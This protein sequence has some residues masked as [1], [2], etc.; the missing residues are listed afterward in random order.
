[1]SQASDTADAKPAPRKGRLFVRLILTL[2][3]LFVALVAALPTILSSDFIRQRGLEGANGAVAGTI[4]L[5]DMS[6]SWTDG[7]SLS[8]LRAWPRGAGDGE[9]LFSLPSASFD[10]A[11]LPVLSG[12]FDVT[13]DVSGFDAQLVLREDGSTNIDEFLGAQ[14]GGDAG[15]GE[16]GGGAPSDPPTLPDLPLKADIQLRDGRAIV[17]DEALGITSGVEG[18]TVS[19][20]SPSASAPIDIDVGAQV[21][22]QDSLAPF[23]LKAKALGADDAG[24]TLAITSSGLQPGAIG[25]PI[26]AAA[27]PLLAG[28]GTGQPPRIE[29]PVDFDVD[30]TTPDLAKL[31]AG[32]VAG[33]KGSIG[34]ELGDGKISGTVMSIVRGALDD[35]NVGG[36]GLGDG[37]LTVGG[38]DVGA[39]AAQTGAGSDALGKLGAANEA[40]Q[41][42]KSL[43]FRGFSSR[44]E[45][46]GAL[47]K[48]ADATLTTSDGETRPLPIEGQF[49]LQ[50]RT[51]DY[52]I[53]WSAL[54]PSDRQEVAALL[55][56]RAISIRGPVGQPA[57]ELGL[58]DVFEQGVQNALQSELD[59][60]QGRAQAE[61]DKAVGELEKKADSKLKEA[62]DKVDP[63]KKAQ[64]DA[65]LGEGATDKLGGDTKKSVDDVIGGLG[66]LFGGKKKKDDKKKDGE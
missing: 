23:S 50:A 56:G 57:I 46:D 43:E 47:A 2:V 34:V 3:V 36:L 19:I 12:T 17:V 59:K 58:A 22:L 6:L 63:E 9:P 4:E 1:M 15:G 40:L 21:R 30:V 39:L 8:G 18:L 64:I 60:L 53:P 42:L 14:R 29:A 61:V 5:D 65:L 26:L 41:G 7:Q 55:D 31:L 49:D 38:F 25:T 62:L 66:G 52:R 33:L 45:L 13:A 44:L 37:G 32:D 11:Y 24:A 48:I 20:T 51:L 16:G 54:L 35:L 28:D 27:F 10:M